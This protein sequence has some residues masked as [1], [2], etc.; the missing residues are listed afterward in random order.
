MMKFDE[1]ETQSSA[2]LAPARGHTMQS[3]LMLT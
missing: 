2:A 1:I 3:A